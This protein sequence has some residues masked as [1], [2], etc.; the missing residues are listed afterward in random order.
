[1]PEVG[2]EGGAKQI[3]WAICSHLIAYPDDGV[4]DRLPLLQ[5]A[6]LHLPEP[7]AS[8]LDRFMMELMRAD[9][10]GTLQEI[11][12]EYVE[13]F[14]TRRRSALYLTYF[15]HGDTRRRGMAILEIKQALEAAGVDAGEKELPDH[16][17]VILE[18]AGTVDP[19]KGEAFLRAYRPGVEMV[20]L[21]L[22]EKDSP[23]A[24]VLQTVCA[25]LP[26]LESDD[27]AAIERLIVEGPDDELVG[28]PTYGQDADYQAG[29][30]TTAPKAWDPSPA[31]SVGGPV[32]LPLPKIPPRKEPRHG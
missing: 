27:R 32:S 28:L 30:P 17:S 4:L 25:T 26:V 31:P 8:R 18:F 7:H 14:D 3:A 29:P 23:W 22:E 10:L 5:E 24:V 20:R 12:Q 13:T 2:I 11:Q 19:E 21:S 16:L 6:A 15:A 9:Q 1:M